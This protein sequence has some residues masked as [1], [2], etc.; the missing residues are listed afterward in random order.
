[1]RRFFCIYQHFYFV[2]TCSF[3]PSDLALTHSALLRASE[4]SAVLK[5]K[6]KEKENV[7]QPKQ[8]E[9]ETSTAMQK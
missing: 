4:N 7:E 5:G 9:E 8:I 3:T 1:M 2:V 6:E